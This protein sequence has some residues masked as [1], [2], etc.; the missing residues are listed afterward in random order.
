VLTIP[1]RFNGPPG[2]GNGGWSAGAFAVA[3]GLLES[4]TVR[5]QAPPPLDT[6]MTV[7]RDNGT[8]EL[9]NGETVVAVS[10]TSPV[11]WTDLPPVDPATARTASRGYPGLARHPFPT[12]FSCGPARA[13]GDGLRIFP[14]RVSADVVAAPWTPDPSVAGKAQVQ[15]A[16]AHGQRDGNDVNDNGQ[17]LVDVPVTWAALDCVGGWSSDLEDR[18]LV[19]GEI[20][21]RI[22]SPPRTGTSYVLVGRLLRTEGRKTWTASAL[23]DEDGSA[24]ARAEHVWIAV[25]WATA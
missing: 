14:G 23:F 2:S 15:G 6:P 16:R 8:A 20:A 18:P 25:D 9:R 19:L 17:D 1:R 4:C 11:A 7:V 10:T 13:P 22:G 12:C 5:L 21:V 3:A 24:L